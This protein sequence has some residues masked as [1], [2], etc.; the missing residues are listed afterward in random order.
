MTGLHRTPLTTSQKVECAAQALAGQE[1]HGTVSELSRRFGISSPDGVRSAGKRRDEVLAE[2]FEK[3]EAQHQ[4]VHV[5]VDE[6]QLQRTIVALRVMAPN[7]IRPIEELL[8]IVYPG[9]RRSYG[10][11]QSIL[12]QAEERARGFNETV[13]LSAITV[14]ALD[15]MFSQGDPVLA[16]VDLDSGYLFGLELRETRGGEDWAQ[17]LNQAKAQ[18]VDA[19]GGGQGCG[20]GDR[21]GCARGVSSGRATR[22]LFSRALRVEQDASA[23]GATR[24]WGDLRRAR[25]RSGIAQDPRP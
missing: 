21:G 10:K 6:A 18:G 23:A 8:P 5:A 17:V 7:A 25:G 24:V 2:H 12:A 3:D 9:V 1:V 4:V 14:S 11:V 19:V 15:E 16:G 22:R 13:D 20:Q